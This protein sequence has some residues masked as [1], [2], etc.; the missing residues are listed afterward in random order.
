MEEWRDEILFSSYILFIRRQ[1][2][3]GQ[4]TCDVVSIRAISF[5]WVYTLHQRKEPN[6]ISVSVIILGIIKINQETYDMRISK[7]L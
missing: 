3:Y 6:L 2:R 5:L 7:K 4:V 1:W